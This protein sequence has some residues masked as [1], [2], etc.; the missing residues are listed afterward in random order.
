M[1]SRFPGE[2]V[3]ALETGNLAVN[4]YSYLVSGNTLVETITVTRRWF[5]DWAGCLFEEE[6][7]CSAT[8]GNAYY[9][10]ESCAACPAD[11]NGNG[12]IEVSDVLE[13][14]SQFGCDNGCSSISIWTTTTPS[15]SL[16]C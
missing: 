7:T 3:G 4:E 15:P 5:L 10:P 8:N 16:T 13:V 2:L 1:T 6:T 12:A 14:L 11:V 9:A